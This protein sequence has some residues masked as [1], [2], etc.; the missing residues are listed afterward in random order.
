MTYKELIEKSVSENLIRIVLSKPSKESTESKVAIRPIK[1]KDKLLFQLTKS[2][3]NKE[4]NTV[5]QIH[6]NLDGKE[7]KAYL[8]KSI[9]VS[10][11]QG[12]FELEGEGY[13]VLSNKKGTI[14]VV[15]N[16]TVS[17]KKESLDH[18]RTKNYLIKEG[19]D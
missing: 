18:N 14:T 11:M 3:G 9:P 10:F 19:D 1:V 16:K 4:S 7:L 6:E 5:K 15:K 2:V 8:E 17:A 12:L 13:S